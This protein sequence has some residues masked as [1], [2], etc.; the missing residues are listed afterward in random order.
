[1]KP[2][3]VIG[4]IC[5]RTKRKQTSTRGILIE[6]GTIKF[7]GE[8]P[9]ADRI[10]LVTIRHTGTHYTYKYLDLMGYTFCQVHWDTMKMV[11][12]DKLGP[13]QYIQTHIDADSQTHRITGE[14]V[15]VT[16]RNPLSVYKSFVYRYAWNEQAFVDH[17]INSFRELNSVIDRHNVHVFR[18]DAE[19]QQAEVM[20]MAE[21][22][23]AVSWT[24]KKYDRNIKT[25]IGVTLAIGQ[26]TM[27]A[28]GILDKGRNN[29]YENPPWPILELAR[30]Y[31]Y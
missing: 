12:Q 29:L 1:M 16:L 18:V 23:N 28:N 8:A 24:Y 3:S 31:G 25:A 10:W 5:A 13:N 22:L 21:F 17:I 27:V 2:A 6:N 20:K 15:I 11:H 4:T 9:Y 19:D 26:K 30:E 7:V 14:K